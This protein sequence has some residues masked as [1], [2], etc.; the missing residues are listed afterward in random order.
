MRIV[1]P[2]TKISAVLL[3][4]IYIYLFVLI[5]QEAGEGRGVWSIRG[6]GTDPLKVG[7]DLFMKISLVRVGQ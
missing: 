7:R 5:G 6:L 3:K 2:I 4:N 1:A